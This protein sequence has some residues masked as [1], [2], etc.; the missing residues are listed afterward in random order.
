[1]SVASL[2]QRV[3]AAESDRDYYKSLVDT[4]FSGDVPA[5]CTFNHLIMA[6]W[7]RLR[8]AEKAK[9]P[10]LLS[11]TTPALLSSGATLSE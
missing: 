4:F 7:G 11:Q 6:K 10:A 2:K 8:L 5:G 9:V 3:V 1:M